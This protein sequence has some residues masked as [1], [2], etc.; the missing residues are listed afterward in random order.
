M[1]PQPLIIWQMYSIHLLFEEWPEFTGYFVVGN[2][3]PVVVRQCDEMAVKQP[4]HGSRKSQPVLDNVWTAFTDPPNMGSLHF[5]A[6]AAI[7]D[8]QSGNRAAIL[9][10]VADNSAEVRIPDLFI[11]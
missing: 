5:G 6:A 7:D 3:K 10:G 9:V 11:D 1:R 4:M 2:E 8:A